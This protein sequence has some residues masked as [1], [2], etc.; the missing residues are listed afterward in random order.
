[1]G[2]CIMQEITCVHIE[3]FGNNDQINSGFAIALLMNSMTVNLLFQ[4]HLPVWLSKLGETE[5]DHVGD[6]YFWFLHDLDCDLWFYSFRD[7]QNKGTFLSNVMHSSIDIS[8]VI[9]SFVQLFLH[10]LSAKAGFSY[11]FMVCGAP[12]T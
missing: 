4:I 6:I 12:L 10:L 1:M 9:H 3:T 2:C 8:V 5:F 11:F 7:S